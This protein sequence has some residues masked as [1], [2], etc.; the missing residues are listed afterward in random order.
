MMQVHVEP[1]EAL[2]TALRAVPEGQTLYVIPTYTAMLEVR[3]ILA[4]RAGR[5]AFWEEASDG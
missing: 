1:S 5:G 3:G 4:R 2:A